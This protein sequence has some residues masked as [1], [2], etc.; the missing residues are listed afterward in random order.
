[1]H[2]QVWAGW[3]HLVQSEDNLE[4]DSFQ[5]RLLSEKESVEMRP[6]LECIS[7]Y[8]PDLLIVENHLLKVEDRTIISIMEALEEVVEPEHPFKILWCFLEVISAGNSVGRFRI[9]I[10]DIPVR[11]PLQPSSPFQVENFANA[12]A[13]QPLI[14]KLVFSIGDIEPIGAEEQK[15]R[16]LLSAILFGGLLKTSYLHA[17]PSALMVEQDPLFRWIELNIPAREGENAEFFHRRWFP[18]P[19]TRLLLIQQKNSGFSRLRNSRDSGLAKQVWAAIFSFAH[20]IGGGEQL[21]PNLSSLRSATKTRMHFYI[22]PYLVHYAEGRYE[23]TSLPVEIWRRM[24]DPPQGL[25]LD[26]H[27]EREMFLEECDAAEAEDSDFVEVDMGVWPAQ[28]RQ[29]ATILRSSASDVRRQIQC[30]RADELGRLLPSVRLLSEWV[31]EWLLTSK[32]N[33]HRPLAVSTA[34]QMLNAGGGRIVGLLG[35]EDP[36]QFQD[37]DSFVDLYMGA[38][39]DAPT[40]HTRV[41]TANA[42]RSFHRFLEK[43]YQVPSLHGEKIFSTVRHGL[44]T[45]DANMICFQTFE[46]ANHWVFRNAKRIYGVE[47]ARQLSLIASIGFFAGLRRS[48]VL[49]LKVSD[50]E[51]VEHG[52]VNLLVRP[53]PSRSLKTKNANRVIPVSLWMPKR[54]LSALLK[55]RKECIGDER[56]AKSY[57]QYLFQGFIKKG[58]LLSVDKRVLLITEALQHASSDRTV[59]FHHLRHSFSNWQLLRVGKRVAEKLQISDGWEWGAVGP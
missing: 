56:G 36:S 12:V 34:Y 45:V 33:T 41:K 43:N 35:D 13:L 49:G 24:I 50:V 58:K 53:N 11:E 30:W 51:G 6:L 27:D 20:L 31:S 1:M 14:D 10:P 15:G 54:V 32:H 18:D 48:E 2:S 38:L 5:S 37:S 28:L 4:L 9:P 25:V 7:E 46:R 17:L 44:N 42:L 52:E 47:V 22:E 59:R 29:L 21:P 16:I 39:E 8:S 40:R 23:S 19:F 26:L 55:W 57:D 3:R